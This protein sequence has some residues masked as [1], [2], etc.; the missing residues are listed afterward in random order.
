MQ[1]DPR[2]D[3]EP[4]APD[5]AAGPTRIRTPRHAWVLELVSSGFQFAVADYFWVSPA[6]F[7]PGSR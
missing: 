6:Q 3:S 4:L 1:A 5:E 7:W 2:S